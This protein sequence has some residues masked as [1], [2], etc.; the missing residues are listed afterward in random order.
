[1]SL[2]H[3]RAG[4][5][6]E[7]RVRRTPHSGMYIERG[8]WREHGIIRPIVTQETTSRRKYIHISSHFDGFQLLI[9][10]DH[11]NFYLLWT[12]INETLVQGVGGTLS[13]LNLCYLGDPYKIPV[14]F[15]DPHLPSRVCHRNP[16]DGI[17]QGR[18]PAGVVF[19]SN[20]N[21]AFYH[22]HTHSYLRL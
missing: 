15:A 1:M 13:V 5:R 2:G 20:V 10:Q 3:G 16:G 19:R 21:P 7:P 4:W 14:L 17:Q 22:N 8:R 9:I 12:A 6:T 18:F 11:H